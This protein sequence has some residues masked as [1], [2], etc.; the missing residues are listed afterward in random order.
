M[1]C[2]SLVPFV[3]CLLA[4]A[5]PAG[6]PA[7]IAELPLLASISQYGITWTLDRPAPCGQFV[8]GDWYVVGEVEIIETTP[9]PAPGRNGSVPD[10]ANIDQ[11][12]CT[13]LAGAR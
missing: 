11:Y 13:P 1:R 9:A 7:G 4:F 12:Y 10:R 6:R 5:R 2:V 8:N 3:T